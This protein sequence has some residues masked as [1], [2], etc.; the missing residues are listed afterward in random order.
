[1]LLLGWRVLGLL[2]YIAFQWA[3]TL[4][5]ECYKLL[6][7]CGFERIARFQW[8]P[9]LGGECYSLIAVANEIIQEFQW[10]PTLGGECYLCDRTRFGRH[11]C[12]NGHPP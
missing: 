11:A 4:G 3:P 2:G 6:E 9:T 8:A 5:G 12:F 7:G 1:M 10:A